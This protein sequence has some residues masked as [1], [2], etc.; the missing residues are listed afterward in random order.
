MG[1]ALEWNDMSRGAKHWIAGADASANAIGLKPLLSGV[2][3]ED[4]G[5]YVVQHNYWLEQMRKALASEIE[6]A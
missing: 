5:L 3:P 1:R 2:K 6:Q 4:E